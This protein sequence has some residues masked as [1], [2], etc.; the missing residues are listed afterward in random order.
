MS[1]I[2]AIVKVGERSGGSPQL[3]EINAGRGARSFSTGAL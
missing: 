1:H 3:Q 2:A